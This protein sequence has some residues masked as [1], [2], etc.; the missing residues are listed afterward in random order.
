MK[1][2]EFAG[3]SSQESIKGCCRTNSV[4]GAHGRA[5]DPGAVRLPAG[6]GVQPALRRRAQRGCISRRWSWLER[7]SP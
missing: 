5:G 7:R 4:R 1:H 6:G 2:A 3:E